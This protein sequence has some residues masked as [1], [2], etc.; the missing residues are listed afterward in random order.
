[1]IIITLLPPISTG[2]RSNEAGEAQEIDREELEQNRFGNAKT[3]IK[4]KEF[5]RASR[6]KMEKGFMRYERDPKI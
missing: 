2:R 1:M 6:Q 5:S 3:S 4:K